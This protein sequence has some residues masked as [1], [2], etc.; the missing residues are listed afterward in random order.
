MFINLLRSTLRK[1]SALAELQVDIQDGFEDDLVV[2]RVNGTEVFREEG[3]TTKLLLGGTDFTSGNA[4]H[5]QVPEGSV[6][7]EVLV[8]S[9]N[10]SRTISVQASQKTYLGVSIQAGKIHYI[11]LDKPFGYA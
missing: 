2:V 8:P 1:E 5:V 3:V 6:D 10:L 4:P 9:K 7:V 11:E